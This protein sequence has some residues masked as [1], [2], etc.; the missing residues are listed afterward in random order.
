[1]TETQ[2][3]VDTTGWRVEKQ[4][5]SAGA[6]RVLD[7]D[8]NQVWYRKPYPGDNEHGLPSIAAPL[9]F[10]RKRDAVAHLQAIREEH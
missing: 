4:D 6:W 1:M 5:Y 9:C 10:D 7:A 2:S 8:G 3:K